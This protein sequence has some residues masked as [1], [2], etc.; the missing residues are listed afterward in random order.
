MGTAM[1][2]IRLSGLYRFPVKSLAGEHLEL[3]RL[4]G[5][6]DGGGQPTLAAHSEVAPT[7]A[8]G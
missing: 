2:E 1:K 7:D 8:A 5:F 3:C 6:G 4:D